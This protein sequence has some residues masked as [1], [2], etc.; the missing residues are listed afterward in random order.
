MPKPAVRGRPPDPELAGRILDGALELFAARGFDGTSLRAVG[1]RLQLSHVAVLHHFTSKRRLYAA[2]LGRVAASLEEL[3]AEACALSRDDRAR[4]RHL[5]SRAL[6]WHLAQP[7]YSRLVLRELLDDPARS[8]NARRFVLA[9]VLRRMVALV[10]RGVAGD[11][12]AATLLIHVI[13]GSAYFATAATTLSR[14]LG[15]PED[16]LL[17]RYR[18][19]LERHLEGALKGRPWNGRPSSH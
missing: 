6:D 7:R 1:A 18:G 19:E 9:D 12:D 14:I 2:V 3:Y 13:G 16:R 11:A 4:A 17:M 10:G 15:E 8:R 5:L